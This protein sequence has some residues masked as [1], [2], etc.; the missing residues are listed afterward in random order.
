MRRGATAFCIVALFLLQTI[1]I[2]EYSLKNSEISKSYH[3]D[4]IF[5]NTGF[6]QDGV[7]TDSNGDI[8]VTRPYINWITPA[9][10]PVLERTG[11]CSASVESLDEVW[12]IGG[13]Q[14]M[15]PQQQNDEEPTDFVEILS[16]H[17]KTW[18]PAP[19]NLPH[20]QQYC[21]AENIGDLI[22]V[23]GDW[24]R[25]SNP[26][27]Y[28]TGRVQIYN[29][30]NNSWYNGTSMP[31]PHERGLGAMAEAN[32][33]LYYAG[34]VRNPNANDATNMTYR[35]DP[36]NDQWTRMADMNH[37]RASFEM[38]NF[39]GQ[40]YAMGGFQ[41]T[42]TWNRQA[43]DYVERYDP[44][45]D[46]WTN[47]SKLPVARFGWSGT[48]L[49]DEIVL[50]GGYNGGPKSEVY[51]WNP[52]EDTWSKG[53][54]IGYIG[55][56]DTIVEEINGS[57]IWATG[58]MSSYA[59]SSWNQM[60]SQDSE[61]QNRT[62]SHTAWI[63][64]PVIDLRPNSNGRAI[65]VQFNLMGNNTQGGQ[66]D[67]QY[68]TA[69]TANS[70]SGKLWQGSDGTSN[71]TFPKGVNNVNIYG[72]ADF[73]QYRIK[74]TIMDLM[75]WD[76]P[77]LES[78]SIISEHA[79]F[80]SSIPNILHP[81]GET[82]TIQ[83]SHDFISNGIMNFGLASCDEFGVISGNWANL[84]H[85]GSSFSIN[86]PD[87]LLD[88][89]N[90]EI[91]STNVG[92]KLID[93]S[94]N[95]GNL[96]GITHLCVKVGT[97]TDRIT[98]FIHSTKIE[99]DRNLEI[100]ISDIGE[101][102][103][104]DTVTGGVPI[105]IGL[106]HSFPSTGMTLESGTLQVR[107][108]FDI[109]T[110]NA[111]NNNNSG[112]IN[113][114]TPWTELTLNQH[115]TIPWTFPT[116]VSGTV[117]ISIEGRT[118]QAL[119]INSVSNETQLVLDNQHP[120]LIASSPINED[121]LDSE[122]DRKLSIVIADVS[123]FNQQ[124]VI[125]QVWV[126][127]I[128]DGVNG[129]PPDGIPQSDEFRQINYTLENQGTFWWFNSTQSDNLNQ[130][131]QLV[132]MRL[133]GHDLAGFEI[134]DNTVWWKTRD[135]KNAIVERVYNPNSNN[136]WEVS[137]GITWNM[138][139]TD[140]N[141]LNDIISVEL[142]LGGDSEFGILYNVADSSCYSLGYNIN[143]DM[144]I[145]NH[146]FNDTE[147]EFS[148]TLF[149]GWG[150]DISKLEEGLV[151]VV[152]TDVDG[153][154]TTSF[155]NLWSYSDDFTFTITQVLDTSGSV[156]GNITSASVVQ[157]GDEVKINGYLAHTS[158]NEP[159]QGEISVSWQGLL[160]GQNW[161][162]S[163][164]IQVND[165]I[166]DATI[167][168]PTTG[169]LMDFEV[170]FMD[171]LQT[172]TIG[173]YE[174]PIF[175]VDSERPVILDPVIGDISRYHLDDVGIGVNI[176][177]D[178]SWTNEL[179][180]S[181]QITS[182]EVQWE[183]I[184]IFM[185]P[186]NEFQGKTIFSYKF[187][188]SKQG[189]P[190][191]LSPEA[192]MTCWAQGQDDSGRDVAL[193]GEDREGEPW[194]SV[195]LSSDGPNIELLSVELDGSFEPGKE[196]RAEITVRNSG[197][198]LQEPFNI[199]VYIIS[200]GNKELVGLYSQSQIASNQGIVKRVGLTVPDGDWELLVLIDEDQKIWEL[201]ESD[202]SFSKQ[203]TAE[204]ELD[205]T[206]YA[207]GAGIAVTILSIFVILKR[208]SN[209]EINEAKKMPSLDELP[210]SGPPQK[211]RKENTS[212]SNSKPRRG[213]PPKSSQTDQSQPI[214]NVA[215]AMAKLSLTTLPGRTED[216]QTKVQSYKSL[217]PGGD[218]EYSSEG[219]FYSGEGL[220]KWRL[221][222]DGSFTRIG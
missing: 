105:N 155:Q 51:H 122:S 119:S 3:E 112:W 199:T 204:E 150:I 130:D 162:G 76:T 77:D 146:S 169:G 133:L 188:F 207:L 221:E 32:G 41:G 110:N 132:Y 172:R 171:P 115:N 194:L 211:S 142:Q 71:S 18:R 75:T 176:E 82:V 158:S 151:E 144:S 68:R 190:S 200:E 147:M 56:F 12:L 52:V 2:A 138:I 159:Y 202:N 123:G 9:A 174:L 143:S 185:L 89:S 67:F 46:T 7:Y 36:S 166:I 135:A 48:V 182:T 69:P 107:A 96:V 109:Q 1:S 98:E 62:E 74:F 137:R 10:G 219:T 220:G 177:E 118:N 161:F 53:N 125:F 99:I 183:P 83:T 134:V 201:D 39:H 164:A 17:N 19:D 34:G 156:T 6:N 140:E 213:P 222:D 95:F 217:P 33:Y 212:N 121:Y 73:V 186:T 210:R 193:E 90:G 154:S 29:I 131:Q 195:P 165:G 203:Y 93:W 43:M 61:F 163:S 141:S 22:I 149:S 20:A 205:F 54:D 57:I 24:A 114:T 79:A 136:I 192:M 97:Y 28:P 26:A 47:L 191:Q 209:D 108:N 117:F 55:H 218:Y 170:I 65:P 27:Q 35:Y 45:T 63:T 66:L 104:G 173:Y 153:L 25:N 38:V 40:L 94:I 91:N 181:C 88:S 16:N 116:N 72:N 148:V 197:E 157:T 175:T 214:V 208:R 145:C 15:D 23:V 13:R 50:V 189:D 60:I 5:N 127:E 129:M 49:N 187:D 184:E 100:R 30:T 87:N 64:S 78:M 168:M 128:D 103:N 160:Q 70:V 86:D 21:E 85:D 124:N 59:Y 81:K 180:I 126:Q 8:K 167:P 120:L 4:N 106:N 31:A 102:S 37:A 178:V 113:Q 215:E 44:A 92:E 11:A 84:S 14:D 206:I 58:D 42:S 179:K 111:S 152:I 196:L 139:I 101:Y 80:M 198:N 216:A